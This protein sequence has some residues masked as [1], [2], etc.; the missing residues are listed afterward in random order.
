MFIYKSPIAD[1][2]YFSEQLK[3]PKFNTIE[4]FSILKKLK[5]NNLT[6]LDLAAGNGANLMYLKK[7]CGNKKYCLGLD[8]NNKLIKQSQNFITFSDLKLKKGNILNIKKNYINNFELITSLGTL[9][10]IKEYEKA[11]LQMIKLNPKYIALSSLFWEGLLDFNIKINTL[12]NKSYK[13]KLLHYSYYNIYSLSNFL[14]FFLKKGYKNIYCKKFEIKKEL[15]NK[16]KDKMGTYT[17]K[18]NKKLLQLSGPI[19]MN[20]YFIIFK[21]I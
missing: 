5:L 14:N 18:K 1:D 21:K 11:S 4:F 2:K 20:W 7:N 16:F 15:P 6:T 17:I 3:K 9:S 10:W 13:R 19:L 12:K 8:Y